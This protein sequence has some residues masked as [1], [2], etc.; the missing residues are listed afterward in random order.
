MR[1]CEAT[2]DDVISILQRSVAQTAAQYFR[3]SHGSILYDA[4][5]EP[6]MAAF[7]AHAVFEYLG[8]EAEIHLERSLGRFLPDSG[9]QRIDMTIERAGELM[10]AIE[11]KRYTAVNNA[12]ADV[13][14]LQRLSSRYPWANC[15]F[16]A[17]CFLEEVNPWPERASKDMHN[18]MG[19]NWY[20]GRIERLPVGYACREGF[21]C[22]QT[23]VIDVRSE[24]PAQDQTLAINR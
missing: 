5:V 23:A 6:L 15:L 9:R 3:W 21:S 11:F 10:F 13:K 2:K 16:V 18:S 24:V 20:L 22:V 7:A 4:G 19:Q 1:I 17:P 8:E 12:A 14:R